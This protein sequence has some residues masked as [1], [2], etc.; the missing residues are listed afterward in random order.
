MDGAPKIFSLVFEIS[1]FEVLLPPNPATLTEKCWFCNKISVRCVCALFRFAF[2][3]GLCYKLA[4]G[5]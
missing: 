1:V 5:R 3:K 4:S 2:F